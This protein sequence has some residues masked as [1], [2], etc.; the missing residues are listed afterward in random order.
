LWTYA[1]L[2][3]TYKTSQCFIEELARIEY[4]RS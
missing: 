4:E 1:L 3:S 2:F